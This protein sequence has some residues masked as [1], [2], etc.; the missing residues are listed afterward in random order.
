MNN[1]GQCVICDHPDHPVPCVLLV[2]RA[3]EFEKCGCR[4][5]WVAD[6]NTPSDIDPDYEQARADAQAAADVAERGG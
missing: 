1:D 4:W 3:W 5:Q 6:H 2:I